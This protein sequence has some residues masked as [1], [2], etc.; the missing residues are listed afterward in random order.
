MSD[1]VPNYPFTRRA[2]IRSTQITRAYHRPISVPSGA[3]TFSTNSSKDH[4]LRSDSATPRHDGRGRI[5]GH[6]SLRPAEALLASAL[7]GNP[8]RCRRRRGRRAALWCPILILNARIVSRDPA[9]THSV[10]TRR[11]RLHS[12]TSGLSCHV[13]T[14][15]TGVGPNT[16]NA[17]GRCLSRGGKVSTKGRNCR[18][19][20]SPPSRSLG[21]QGGREGARGGSSASLETGR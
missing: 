1:Y 19:R 7:S 11:P 20:L 9:T 18:V 8:A 21:A 14:R 17:F 6:L 16:C 15:R 3:G 10:V 4:R 5:S 2:L 13:L 12:M